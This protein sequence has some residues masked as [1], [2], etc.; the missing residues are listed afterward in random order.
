M[1][2]TLLEYS[3]LLNSILLFCLLAP[4]I[5]YLIHKKWFKWRTD[6]SDYKQGAIDY[7]NSPKSIDEFLENIN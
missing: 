5:V 2:W 3:L 7:C 6:K 1:K 4:N